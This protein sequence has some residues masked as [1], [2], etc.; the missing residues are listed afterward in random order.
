MTSQDWSFR[1]R[2]RA[3]VQADGMNN[4]TF[5]NGMSIDNKNMLT[6]QKSII[7]IVNISN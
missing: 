2:E 7:S 6:S 4:D 5:R 3:D 1:E